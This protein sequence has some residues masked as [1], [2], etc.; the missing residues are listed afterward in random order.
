MEGGRKEGEEEVVV[1]VPNLGVRPF[2]NS[3]FV[4]TK[5]HF[6]ETISQQGLCVVRLL[7]SS[8]IYGNF[9]MG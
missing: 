3:I 4:F 5:F 2:F 6:N 9:M 7:S 1:L 8:P